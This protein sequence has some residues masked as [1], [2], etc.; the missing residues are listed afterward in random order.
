MGC[1]KSHAFMQWYHWLIGCVYCPMKCSL[2]T[3]GE[4]LF[5]GVWCLHCNHIFSP[6]NSNQHNFLFLFLYI[7]Q[8]LTA[9]STCTYLCKH[10]N[11]VLFM[12]F[13]IFIIIFFSAWL[14]PYSLTGYWF[15]IIYLHVLCTLGNENL[16]LLRI[17]CS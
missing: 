7:A 8:A 2:F 16:K 6:F 17:A 15:L 10:L 5:P 9:I 14:F 11:I 1:H 13:R 3:T 4:S 12:H